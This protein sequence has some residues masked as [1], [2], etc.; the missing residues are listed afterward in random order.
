MTHGP[1]PLGRSAMQALGDIP[2]HATT[3]MRGE[4]TTLEVEDGMTRRMT[5]KSVITERALGHNLRRS[6]SKTI[7]VT[8]A[9]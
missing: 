7:T 3:D 2:I 4:R 1:L 6:E 8:P 9:P 5:Q